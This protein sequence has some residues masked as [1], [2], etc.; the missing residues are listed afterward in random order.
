[1]AWMK[2]QMSVLLCL[3]TNALLNIFLTIVN[4]G[5]NVLLPEPYFLFYGPDVSICG[6]ETRYYPVN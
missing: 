6:G 1:M 2:N 4:P 3:G 5:E